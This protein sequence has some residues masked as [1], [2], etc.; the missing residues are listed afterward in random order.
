MKSEQDIPLQPVERSIPCSPY[1]D[2]NDHW[3]Y[4]KVTVQAKRAGTRRAA[5]YSYETEKTGSA[6]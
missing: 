1:V 2:P 6:R 5:G 3:I 4:D